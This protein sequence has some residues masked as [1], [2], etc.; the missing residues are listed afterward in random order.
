[1]SS[2]LIFSFPIRRQ[3]HMD[4]PLP[5]HH[6]SSKKERKNMKLNQLSMPGGQG[7]AA[8]NYNT[9]SI[10]RATPMRITHGLII[11]TCMPLTFLRIFI[12]KTPLQLDG[13]MYKRPI[14]LPHCFSS[15][16]SLFSAHFMSHLLSYFTMSSGNTP[17]ESHANS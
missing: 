11:R 3:K 7:K 15:P 13:Q 5:D 16:T 1:M 14:I 17:F 2:I 6:Q 9:S 10:G 12:V 8:E 4:P